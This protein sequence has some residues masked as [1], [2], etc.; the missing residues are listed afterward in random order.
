M[1]SAIRRTGTTGERALEFAA[2]CGGSRQR[3]ELPDPHPAGSPKSLEPQSPDVRSVDRIS[4]AALDAVT[5]Y[6]W[7]RPASGGKFGFYADDAAIA[8]WVRAGAVGP[9]VPGVTGDGL[10]R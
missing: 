2:G 10:G 5:K 7:Q 3:P 8:G 4:R 1:T 6:P 9:A